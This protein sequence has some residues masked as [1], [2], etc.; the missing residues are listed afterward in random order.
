MAKDIVA[1]LGSLARSCPDHGRKICEASAH[2]QVAYHY[3][4]N[5]DDQ[6][7]LSELTS[8]KRRLIMLRGRLG[9]AV[10]RIDRMAAQCGAVVEYV[11]EEDIPDEP[12]PQPV[13]PYD[14][15]KEWVLKQGTITNARMQ[16]ACDL[17]HKTARDYINKMIA[18]GLLR[19]E[20][21]KTYTLITQSQS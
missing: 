18:D 12:E 4:L 9:S 8:A 7:T 15:A 17:T 10:E 3:A 20:S 1:E 13:D 19:R 2:L 21:K 14:T 5:G 6:Q 16:K 11:P